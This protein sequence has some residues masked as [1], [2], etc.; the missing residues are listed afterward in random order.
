[1]SIAAAPPGRGHCEV[2]A[3]V[4]AGPER[5]FARLD[6]Q[7][8]LAEHMR[9]PS[10]MMGGG[11]MAYVFDAG[12]GQ[13]VGSR[14]RM[15]GRA[16]GLRL[17]VDQVVTER[18][19]PRRKSWRTTGEPRLLIIGKYEMGFE[20]APA[21]QGSNLRVWIDYD[22]PSLRWPGVKLL[23]KAYARWCVD[24]MAKDAVRATGRS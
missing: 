9:R 14:F 10:L 8:R 21:A 23:T 1:M 5:V 22:P 18:D 3:Y 24:Q 12:A 2:T 20:V 16:F 15:S 13:A 4:P 7:K 17:S 11:R 6:D 19:P